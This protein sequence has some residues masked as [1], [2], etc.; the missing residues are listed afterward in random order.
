MDD[1]TP[2]RK[3]GRGRVPNKKYSID[4][5]EG[6]DILDSD[7]ERNAVVP[8][9]FDDTDVD[10]DF[11]SDV[12][13]EEAEAT[14]TDVISGDEGSDGSG[15]ATPVEDY[16]DAV[17]YASEVEASERPKTNIEKYTS[18]RLRQ[19]KSQHSLYKKP[20]GN[21][22][23]PRGVPEPMTCNRKSD[24]MKHI[25]GGGTEDIL[26]AVRSREQWVDNP[27]LPN[28]S[29]VGQ[30]SG[31]LAFSFSHTTEKRHMEA[32]VGWDWYYKHGGQ[33]SFA[34]RQRTVLLKENEAFRHLPRPKADNHNFLMGP[35][36]KQRVFNLAVGQSMNAAQAWEP[37]DLAQ[38]P[39][40]N[41]GLSGN[42]DKR[43]RTSWMLNVGNKINCLDWAA[44][45]EE[46]QYLAI[47]GGSVKLIKSISPAS[48]PAF[49]PSSPLP[50]SL[51][52]WAFF[53]LIQSNEAS[54]ICASR[55]PQLRLVCC[56]EWGGIRH[57][58]W[59]H[60]PRTT[61]HV[62]NLGIISVG[63]LAGIWG[64]GYA[65]VLD[66]HLDKERT[67]TTHGMFL[68]DTNC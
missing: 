45:H 31:G 37:A 1:P 57:L 23:H 29:F 41:S 60:L 36:E 13:A 59:C 20:K 44:N 52:I 34:Q 49:T 35:Y 61:R 43:E 12:A 14:D 33:A 50:A 8:E 32:T 15:I 46:T 63:L 64:D 42:S 19:R 47:A 39:S 24:H 38:S 27:T 4:P 7:T 67:S 48:A 3:S 21:N 2:T 58:K 6:L 55:P 11:K 30:G 18:Q 26:Q 54:Q 9:L 25:F 16:E 51:Q 28:R 5:F 65:R 40:Q 17:S 53:A 56:T 66:I 22:E 68:P 62:D 10:Q